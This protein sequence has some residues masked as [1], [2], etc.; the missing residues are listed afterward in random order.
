MV[1]GLDPSLALR[2]GR[3]RSRPSTRCSGNDVPRQYG[4]TARPRAGGGPVDH[5][6]DDAADFNGAW[7][8]HPYF[9]SGVAIGSDADGTDGWSVASD[10]TTVADGGHTVSA[11][12]TDR[13]GQTGSDAITVTV[14]NQPDAAATHVGDLGSAATTP[15]RREWGRHRADR[16]PRRRPREA[17]RLITS[18][19]V[20]R[21]MRSTAADPSGCHGSSPL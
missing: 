9:D 17:A 12:A 20:G 18:A 7:S 13:A 2:P 8:N 4:H 16:S 11:V 15:I 3:S 19:A 21:R 14:D 5:P 10:T 6:A 1:G